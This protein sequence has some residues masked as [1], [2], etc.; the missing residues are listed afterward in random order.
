MTRYA[1]HRPRAR[2]GRAACRTQ[3]ATGRE[4]ATAAQPKTESPLAK[5]EILRRA[6]GRMFRASHFGARAVA[7][8]SLVDIGPRRS[9]PQ[10]TKSLISS[11]HVSIAGDHHTRHSP[12]PALAS[13]PA[14]AFGRHAPSSGTR[15]RAPHA[16]GS[17]P[18]GGAGPRRGAEARRLSARCNSRAARSTPPDPGSPLSRD[19]RSTPSR[20]LHPSHPPPADGARTERSSSASPPAPTRP[21]KW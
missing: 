6:P 7:R 20:A 17:T 18:S 2:N 14:L 3:R 21:G 9:S 11:K 15:L 13:R 10:V 5:F 16:F 8:H 12:S 4:L 1:R 19:P